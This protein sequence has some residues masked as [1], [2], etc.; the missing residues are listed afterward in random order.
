M[1]SLPKSLVH[2]GSNQEE[3]GRGLR[4]SLNL[5]EWRENGVDVPLGSREAG[6]STS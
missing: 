4:Y 3:G 1:S 5:R 6:D 2:S